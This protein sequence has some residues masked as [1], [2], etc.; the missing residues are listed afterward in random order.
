MCR[1]LWGLCP[2]RGGGA[3]SPSNTVWPGLRSTCVPSF[4]LIHP[5]VWPQCTNVTDRTDRQTTDRQHRANLFTNGRPKT[6]ARFSRRPGNGES[7]FC[8]RRFINLS[9]TYLDTYPLTYSPVTHT[10]QWDREGTGWPRFSWKM[11]H[12]ALYSAGWNSVS[13]WCK[14]GNIYKVSTKKRPPKYNGVVFEILFK[15]HWNFYNI[16]WHIFV[17]CVQKNRGNLT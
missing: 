9:L 14:Q 5:T 13:E 15:H 7:L 4:I 10:G 8:F 11:V 6:E 16:I 2:F 12:V 17:H 3:G 1:K